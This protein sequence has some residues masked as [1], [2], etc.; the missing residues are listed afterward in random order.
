MSDV[1]VDNHTSDDAT[2]TTLVMVVGSIIFFII[3]GFFIALLILVFYGFYWKSRSSQL[4]V[5]VK[6]VDANDDPL[7]NNDNPED[8]ENL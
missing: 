5:T 6:Y 2:D 4:H 1:K 8:E 7:L 3:I